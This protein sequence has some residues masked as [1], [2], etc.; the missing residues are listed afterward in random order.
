MYLFAD[1]GTKQAEKKAAPSETRSGTEQKK[2]AEK[3]PQLS[4]RQFFCGIFPGRTI[5]FYFQ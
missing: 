3:I 2:W 4:C 5:G 1:S